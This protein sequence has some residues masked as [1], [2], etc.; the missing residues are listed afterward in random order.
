MLQV[1]LAR[2]SLFCGYG[3]QMDPSV[4]L[5]FSGQKGKGCRPSIFFGPTRDALNLITRKLHACLLIRPKTLE[6]L[7]TRV[8]VIALPGGDPEVTKLWA[9]TTEAMGQQIRKQVVYTS[10]QQTESVLERDADLYHQ[11]FAC[12]D[13][14]P[15][16]LGKLKLAITAAVDSNAL[17]ERWTLSGLPSTYEA[18][19]VYWYQSEIGASVEMQSTVFYEKAQA[20]C[21]YRG[22][23][24]FGLQA[25]GP[26]GSLPVV[27]AETGAAQN[28]RAA[29][30]LGDLIRSSWLLDEVIGFAHAATLPDHAGWNALEPRSLCSLGATEGLIAWS[31]P[32]SGTFELSFR[33]AE[34]LEDFE[35][36]LPSDPWE[37]VRTSDQA[38]VKAQR[39]APAHVSAEVKA[40]Y[41]RTLLTLRQMQD[42]EGGIIA[43]PEF[44]Y[45]LTHCGGYGYCWGRD[46]GFISYAMDVCGLYEESARF[47]RYMQRCQNKDGSFLHRHDMKGHLGSSWG[48]LQP[49]ETGSVLFGLWQHF[50][51]AHDKALMEEL[52]ETIY[53]AADWL[54]KARHS[55]D[56]ELP[57][58]GHDLWEEREGVHLYSVSAMTA[59]L[60][61]ATA[62]AKELGWSHPELWQQRAEQLRALSN[63]ERFVVKTPTKTTFARS[64]R[65]RI[66]P[67]S[68]PRLEQL[69]LSITRHQNALGRVVYEL[70]QD[71]VLDIS[72]LAISY[73]YHTLDSKHAQAFEQLL[74]ALDQKLWRPE[75]GGHGR[76]EGDY[77][78]DGN[79]WVL[80][81]LWLALAAAEHGH[82]ELAKKAWH[83]VLK[84]M[85][86]EGL[87]PE[88][89]DPQNGGPAWV[90]PLTWS[91]AMFALAIQQLPREVVL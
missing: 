25:H 20:L 87:L 58:E 85:P 77:Y 67:S 48:L 44:H 49:D 7:Q 81:S 83:W 50:Q 34:G 70:D 26:K 76:Y 24:C 80:A 57:I 35:Q 86:E 29:H 63:S 28:H 79:P 9:D 13:S 12:P 90:L 42:P 53:K 88:Q 39:A 31:L 37:R 82:T 59:G 30:R 65:R 27:F 10:F 74:L 5:A 52:R 51:L 15:D 33:M 16:Q 73:P 4:N 19:L 69:G 22:S 89:I 17:R 62:I 46:A 66:G 36:A 55:F 3:T 71:F 11:A 40:L 6:D 56:P 45:A 21:S 1:S 75:Q 32:E 78:R 14:L 43:A 38:W 47:Y 41:A 8:W 68:V 54:A 18:Q 2:D 72:Q 64:L 23:V 60:E 61:A 91:H 84:H